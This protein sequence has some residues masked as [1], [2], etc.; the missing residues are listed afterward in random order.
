[1]VYSM[2]MK[3]SKSEEKWEHYL[4]I[5]NLRDPMARKRPLDGYSQEAGGA[6]LGYEEYR[7][8]G[9][10]I[11]RE[12]WVVCDAGF[13]FNVQELLKLWQTMLYKIADRPVSI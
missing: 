13:L 7:G 12:R 4:S 3:Y 8:V 9:T 2:S 11:K 5:S 1:M 10:P 6:H